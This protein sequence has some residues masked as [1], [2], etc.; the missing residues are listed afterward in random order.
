MTNNFF[1]DIA[2]NINNGIPKTKHDLIN[3]LYLENTQLTQAQ[4]W[5]S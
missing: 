3:N 1:S 5:E 2:D 4:L